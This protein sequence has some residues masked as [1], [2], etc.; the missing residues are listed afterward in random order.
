MPVRKEFNTDMKEDIHIP[1]VT[2]V[3][4]AVARKINELNEQEWT[5][6]LMNQNDHEITNVLVASKGYGE[7]EGE[8]QQTSTLRHYFE[9]LDAYSATAVELIQPEVFHLNNEYWVSYYHN[10]QIYDK[11]FIFVPDSIQET[12]LQYIRMLDMEGI[13][14]S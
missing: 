3:R 13:L 6:F 1:D 5:V 11:K 2:N 14:H 10:S 4:V 7:K 8:K 9:K 12:N